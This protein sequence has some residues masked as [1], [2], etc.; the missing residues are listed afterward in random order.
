[1]DEQFLNQI[2]V[3]HASKYPDMSLL[4]LKNQILNSG[5][6]PTTLQMIMAQAKDPTLALLLSIFVGGF[7]VDRFYIGDVGMGI[8]KLLTCGGLY[9]WWLI[10]IF[11]IMN[12]T[13]EKNLMML[14]S[15]LG[16]MGQFYG[17]RT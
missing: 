5:I 2:L 4:T 13:K 8:G 14:T 10:D 7:G 3:T 15:H 6:D 16:T 9:I 17:S 12:A 11:L 1:M